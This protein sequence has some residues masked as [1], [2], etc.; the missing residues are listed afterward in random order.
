MILKTK[1]YLIACSTVITA[2]AYEYTKLACEWGTKSFLKGGD[3]HPQ[4]TLPLYPPLK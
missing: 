3:V 2:I 1:D 4:N